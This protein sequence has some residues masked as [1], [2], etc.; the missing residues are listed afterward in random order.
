LRYAKWMENQRKAIRD[1]Q[2]REKTTLAEMSI[3]IGRA[4]SYFQQF[5]GKKASPAELPEDVRSELSRAYRIDPEALRQG[6]LVPLASN[7]E[8][9]VYPTI[10][11]AGGGVEV[12]SGF[13]PV[14]LEGG[15]AGLQFQV[16]GK[17]RYEVEVDLDRLEELKQVIRRIELFLLKQAGKSS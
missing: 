2:L 12:V 8:R 1:L 9:K 13:Q 10:V 17:A 3:K 15:G 14:I 4:H 16:D 5:L 6:R 7:P 11:P